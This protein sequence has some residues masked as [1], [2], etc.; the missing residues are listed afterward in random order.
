MSLN[1]LLQKA[2][3]TAITAAGDTAI[4]VTYKRVTLG[5]YDGFT[6][7]QAVTTSDTVLTTFLYG[8]KDNEVDWFAGDLAM[9]K[10]ILNHADLGFVPVNE[11]WIEIDGVDWEVKSVKSFPG[12]TGYIVFLRKT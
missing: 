8:L 6:D 11:D 2:I 5:V 3:T 9:R 12:E 4:Q 10:C 7:T 1:S